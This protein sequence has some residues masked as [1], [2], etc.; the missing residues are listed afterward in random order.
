M[1]DQP[2][3]YFID[4]PTF[5]KG[6]ISLSFPAIA[7]S[8]PEKYPIVFVDLNLIGF[9]D[10]NV[11]DFKS[12][13]VFFVGIK[14]SL[15]NYKYAIDTTEK[16]R[17]YNK[18]LK[19]IWGGEYPTLFPKEASLY[20][21]S[22]V[23]GAFENVSSEI[24]ADLT[25]YSLKRSYDGKKNYNCSVLKPARYSI[26]K[27]GKFYSQTMGFPLETSR[28]CDKKCTF[29]MVHTMQPLN[30]FKTLNQLNL[31][32]KIL[33]GKYV[34]VIDYN[35][36]SNKEHLDNVIKAF[37][38]SKTLGWMGEMCLESLDDDDLLKRL[39]KSKCRIIYCGLESIDEESLLSI[40]KAKTNNVEN[41]SRIIRKAQ[42]HGIQIAA[43]IIIGMEGANKGNI[44][45][46]FQFYQSIGIIYAKLTFL[47]Y[48]PGTKV[49]QSMKRVGAYLTDKIE[50]FDGNH[51][52]FLPRRV[53]KEEVMASL[54]ENIN[55]FYSKRNILKRAANAGLKDLEFQEFIHFNLSYREVYLKWIKNDIFNNEEGFKK[56][57]NKKYKKSNAI[58]QSEKT[59]NKIRKKRMLRNQ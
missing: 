8:L 21:D 32:L 37:T 56:L 58:I 31:E 53:N 45:A 14:V 27:N 28:G 15:Q 41:Y 54:I 2:L 40:N 7:A 24:L 52:T 6:V 50:Y 57:L 10:K 25:L 29:C 22:I 13:N 1:P 43:G 9:S 44:D 35:I 17:T 23:C 46:T 34:N 26:L 19:I 47:T 11:R 49:F 4:L 33:N 3:I 12:G 18:N 59:I 30:N 16:L 39:A 55:S 42:S 48:N 20:A 5:P 36:G 51:F 38:S